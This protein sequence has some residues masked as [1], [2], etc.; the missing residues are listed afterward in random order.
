MNL[1]SYSLLLALSAMAAAAAAAPVDDTLSSPSASWYRDGFIDIEE[2]S[3]GAVASLSVTN[4]IDELFTLYQQARYDEVLSRITTLNRPFRDAVEPLSSSQKSSLATLLDFKGVVLQRKGDLLLAVGAHKE[5]LKLLEEIGLADKGQG[6]A[7]RNNLA[8]ANYLLGNYE[9]SEKILTVIVESKAVKAVERVRAW[10]NR[11]LIYTDL[12]A[13]DKALVDFSHA[14]DEA[15]MSESLQLLAQILNNEGRGLTRRKSWV[16]AEAAFAEAMPLAEQLQ[17][18]A[19]TADLLDSWAEMLVNQG[20][21][22]AALDKSL[23]AAAAEKQVNA[24]LIRVTLLKNRGR[25]LAGLG[26]S[27]EALRAYQEALDLAEEKM[28]PAQKRDVLTYRAAL[29]ASQKK[30]N[31]AIE[32]Y[33]AAIA[34]AEKTRA[35]LAGEGESGFIEATAQLYRETVALLLKRNGKGDAEAA[36]TLLERS[37]SAQLQEQMAEEVPALRDKQ[38]LKDINGARGILRQEAALSAT[39]QRALATSNPDQREISRLRQQLDRVRAEAVKALAELSEKY[40]GRYDHFVPAAVDP[41]YLKDIAA[42][43]PPGGLLVAYSYGDDGLYTFLVSGDGKIEFRQNPDVSRAELE[44]R[45]TDYRALITRAET[46][47]RDDLRIDNWSDP[48][49]QELRD[50]TVWLYRQLL[51]PI[52]DRIKDSEQVI[53]APTGMMYYLPFHALG[54][55]DETGRQMQYLALEKRV[56]YVSHASLLKA[57]DAARGASRHARILA[58]GDVQFGEASML[59]QLDASKNE[60]QAVQD[61]FGADAVLLQDKVATKQ[62]LLKALGQ[63]SRGKKRA[64]ADGFDFMLI[65]THGILNAQEPRTSYLAMENNNKLTAQEIGG[66]DLRGISLVT[67]SA[68]ETALASENPG[69]DLMSLGEYVSLAGASSVL[70][71]LWKVDDFQTAN[72]MKQFYARLKSDANNKLAAL[73]TAQIALATHPESTHP[74]FWSPFVLYGRGW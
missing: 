32:D 6:L 2:A 72:L 61:V 8:V 41:K 18:H 55:P 28:I 69:A 24:P 30:L 43:L 11:G 14:E 58:F 17:D 7:V 52:A 65:S 1:W 34:E 60:L 57:F 16:K 62:N 49:W 9:E 35:H 29:Y 70:A 48:K 50:S 54:L 68:C 44:K 19:L 23:A 12:G 31:P 45:I 66:L 42:L 71:T 22:Q 27:E 56:S 13:S 63:D 15:R 46:K 40:Q 47:S 36:F 73:Q 21:F 10:N 5:A 53:F 4:T 67:L 20:K 51:A 59:N 39:L 33:Q 37:R 74:F 26:K 25:A 3:R 64:A 38:A